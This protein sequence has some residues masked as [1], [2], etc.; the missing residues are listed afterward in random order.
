MLPEKSWSRLIFQKTCL[1]I[2]YSLLNIVLKWYICWK[3]LI[4][5]HITTTDLL[6][7][8]F[9]WNNMK[10]R[11]KTQ[12][13]EFV[14]IMYSITPWALGCY[15][16]Y[17]SQQNF[18]IPLRSQNLFLCFNFLHWL[19]SHFCDKSFFRMPQAAIFTQFSLHIK[20]KALY[21]HMNLIILMYLF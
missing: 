8:F 20:N 5:C 15:F 19:F 11:H 4:S 12:S 2:I 13:T 17:N 16:N 14:H 9:C 1:I 6:L 10:Q 18:P 21:V 3:T 7:S